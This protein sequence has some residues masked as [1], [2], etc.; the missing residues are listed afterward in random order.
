[1]S[2]S[3]VKSLQKMMMRAGRSSREP[4]GAFVIGIEAS[5]RHVDESLN[6]DQPGA[7]A[8]APLKQVL[9]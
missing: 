2:D 4:L 1:M 8:F 6:V 3:L 5:H 7:E 9:P